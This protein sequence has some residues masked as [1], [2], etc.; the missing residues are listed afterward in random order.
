MASTSDYETK[1]SETSVGEIDSSSE[2]DWHW[3]TWIKH[4]QSSF[5]QCEFGQAIQ[6]LETAIELGWNEWCQEQAAKVHFW[7]GES[8]TQYALCNKAIRRKGI[9]QQLEFLEQADDHFRFA[10]KCKTKMRPS[11]ILHW[12]RRWNRVKKLRT[13]IAKVKQDCNL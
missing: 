3:S 2:E 8:L 12:K 7:L 11:L 4:G 5:Q 6:C 13:S 1:G 9:C 10:I